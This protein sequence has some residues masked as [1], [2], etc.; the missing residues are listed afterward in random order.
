MDNTLQSV[1]EIFVKAQKQLDELT[2][3]TVLQ[4]KLLDNGYRKHCSLNYTT[5][6]STDTLYQKRIDDDVGKRY[7]INAWYYPCKD[8][9][10]GNISPESIMVE[11][12]LKD[13]DGDAYLTVS[14]WVN[15]DIVKAEEII[16]R[17]WLSE[18]CGYD[19]KWGEC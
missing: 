1:D 7:Y 4:Q 14:P 19:E 16:D 6:H 9:N 17:I 2:P 3:P 12:Q 8:W 10:N 15:N 13:Q 5:F 11:V 18:R